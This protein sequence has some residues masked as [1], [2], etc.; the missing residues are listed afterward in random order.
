M[1][2]GPDD[3]GETVASPQRVRMQRLITESVLKQLDERRRHLQRLQLWARYACLLLLMVIPILA[4]YLAYYYVWEGGSLPE[5]LGTLIAAL[6]AFLGLV[7][8]VATWE[9]MASHRRM[10]DVLL[11]IE[12]NR[13]ALELLRNVAEEHPDSIVP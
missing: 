8:T 1:D 10:Q 7:S 13:L 5:R 12:E 6:M 4:A 2:A 9:T 3:Q 11:S